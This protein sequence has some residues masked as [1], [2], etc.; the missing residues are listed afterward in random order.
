VQERFAGYTTVVEAIPA[1][2]FSFGID[3]GYPEAKSGRGTG[4]TETSRTG[5]N[6]D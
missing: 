3:Q 4:R 5:T 2:V 1:E 6:N